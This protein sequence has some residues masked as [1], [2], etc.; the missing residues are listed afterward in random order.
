MFFRLGDSFVYNFAFEVF[1][2]Y[3]VVRHVSARGP[4]HVCQL[5][6]RS[7]LCLVL[8]WT[9]PWLWAEGRN[10]KSHERASSFFCFLVC[11]LYVCGQATAVTPYDPGTY[12][13]EV[14]SFGLYLE[15]FCFRFFQNFDFR[16]FFGG[17]F[18]AFFRY[19]LS[20]DKLQVTPHDPGTQF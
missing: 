11:L 3:L 8:F 14:W 9:A 13:L 6:A 5:E 19:F 17:Y 2:T 15:T 7:R 10:S 18:W 12:F 4:C 20:V 16:A 1:L